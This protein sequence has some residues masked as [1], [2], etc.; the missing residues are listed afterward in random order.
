MSVGEFYTQKTMV[1]AE[2][3]VLIVIFF[4][5]TLSSEGWL[6]AEVNSVFKPTR[7]SLPV[8]S[9]EMN[10]DYSHM[11]KVIRSKKKSS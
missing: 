7:K 10:P 9:Y 2:F 8:G 5:L 1:M 11:H 6:C 4:R 3:T